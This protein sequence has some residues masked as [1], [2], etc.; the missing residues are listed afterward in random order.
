MPVIDITGQR[1]G[2]L[3]VLVRH[4]VTTDRKV[5]WLCRCDCGREKVVSGKD[6]RSGHTASCGC[7]QT[8][9]AAQSRRTHGM[10]AT[11][12]C[13]ALSAT[14]FCVSTSTRQSGSLVSIQPRPNNSPSGLRSSRRRAYDK[15]LRGHRRQSVRLDLR[16]CLGRTTLRAP[17][18]W[19]A[20]WPLWMQWYRDSAKRQSP[21]LQERRQVCCSPTAFFFFGGTLSAFAE[22]PA[23]LRP[24]CPSLSPRKLR[25]SA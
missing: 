21:T 1:F 12:G 3:T 9:S 8:E 5:T 25:G 18:H 22:T 6:M 20:M 15:A 24:F 23:R 4:G 2:M 14:G 7:G 11:C 17:W 16:I 10:R 19:V 13:N